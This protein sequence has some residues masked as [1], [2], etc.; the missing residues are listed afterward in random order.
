MEGQL[1]GF[2]GK[3][4]M[5]RMENEHKVIHRYTSALFVALAYIH[6]DHDKWLNF[7]NMKNQYLKQ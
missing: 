4:W 5:I 6:D 2:T 3:I 7:I 1:T